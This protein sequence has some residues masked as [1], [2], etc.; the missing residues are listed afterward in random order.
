MFLFTM[1]YEIIL[2]LILHRNI[3][4][5]KNFF[6]YFLYLIGLSQD[7]RTHLMFPFRLR[8]RLSENSD[9]DKS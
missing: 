6:K 3:M 1:L 8:I 7:L 5:S 2:S 4:Y 9:D